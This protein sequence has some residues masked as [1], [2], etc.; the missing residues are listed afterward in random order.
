MV[1]DHQ[2]HI[3]T[4]SIQDAIVKCQCEQ[5]ISKLKFSI[6]I[7]ALTLKKKKKKIERDVLQ[8]LEHTALWLSQG[9]IA[10]TPGPVFLKILRILSESS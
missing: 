4:D 5:N 9:D 6:S 10:H 1:A 7:L 2:L 8:K 3:C